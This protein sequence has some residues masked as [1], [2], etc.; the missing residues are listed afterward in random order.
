[1]KAG[2]G[3][4]INPEKIRVIREW[5]VPKIKKGVRASLRFANYYKAF[6]DKFAITAASFTALTRK[7]IFLWISEA[8]KAFESLKKNFISALIL[9]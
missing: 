7:H 1:M 5:E 2:A 4:R 6:I 3:L 8:Q 9:A